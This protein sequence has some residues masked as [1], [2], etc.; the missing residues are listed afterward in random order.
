MDVCL[1]WVLCVLSGRGLCDELITHPEE[2]YRHWC[3]VLCDLE[4]TWMRKPWPTGGGGAVAPNDKNNGWFCSPSN[5]PPILLAKLL[6]RSQ[7]CDTKSRCLCRNNT[8]I[9]RN[10]VRLWILLESRVIDGNDVHNWIMC[11]LNM[12]KTCYSVCEYLQ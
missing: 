8:L 4:M 3:V 2:S 6:L 5:P 7:V 1:L 10:C 11:R 9:L 12:N